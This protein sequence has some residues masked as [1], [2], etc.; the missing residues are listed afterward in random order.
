MRNVGAIGL[1]LWMWGCGSKHKSGD[2][3]VTGSPTGEVNGQLRVILAFSRPMVLKDHVGKVAATAPIALA[4]ELPHEARWSDEKTLVVVPTASL[5]LS[6]RFTAVV[7][8]DT[9]A[10]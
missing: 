4:P 2:L 6:T 9:R 1:A 3:T 7:P 10:L 8:G 5:P